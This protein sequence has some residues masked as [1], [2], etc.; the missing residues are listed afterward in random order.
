MIGDRDART[1]VSGRSVFW[2]CAAGLRRPVRGAGGSGPDLCWWADRLTVGAGAVVGGD[3][4]RLRE[5]LE[6]VVAD[7]DEDVVGAAQQ[8]ARDRQRRAAV[9]KPFTQQL[10]VSMV[11]RAAPAGA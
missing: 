3:D 4:L 11:G 7:G 9:A 2:G 8:L 1:G 6:Q 5:W 10:V